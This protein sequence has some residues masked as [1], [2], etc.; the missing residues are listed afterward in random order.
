[1][2]PN[3]TKLFFGVI[4]FLFSTSL[5][6]F[7]ADYLADVPGQSAWLQEGGRGLAMFGFGLIYAV[8]GVLLV[9][10]VP[11]SLGFLLAADVA[12]IDALARNYEKIEGMYRVGMIGLVLVIVY[13]FAAYR[14]RDTHMEVGA[15]PSVGSPTVS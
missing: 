2:K 3:Y 11:V 12:L 15:T 7:S 8:V 13:L 9:R 14:C 1:M 4:I 5:A 10:I 6:Y